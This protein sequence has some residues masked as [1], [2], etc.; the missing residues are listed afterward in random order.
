MR[1][2]N[3]GKAPEFVYKDVPTNKL[4]RM[5]YID[6]RANP[7]IFQ[8]VA[9]TINWDDEETYIGG[10]FSEEFIK[11]FADKINWSYLTK[12]QS[13][14]HDELCKY[15]NRIDWKVASQYQILPEPIISA[16]R[17]EV[18]WDAIST[19]QTLNCAFID[20][21]NEYVNWNRVSKSQKLN[22][23]LLIKY[24]DKI[25]WTMASFYQNSS[26]PIEFI[27]EHPEYIE[28][29]SFSSRL[30]END[31]LI[32]EE[33]VDYINWDNIHFALGIEFVVLN[34]SYMNW[35]N[36]SR[37]E[38]FTDQFIAAYD[39]E[40]NWEIASEYQTLS[41]DVIREHE[42]RVD[43]EKISIHQTLSEPFIHEYK[44]SVSWVHIAFNQSLS[45]EFIDDHIEYLHKYLIILF[46]R[47]MYSDEFINEFRLPVPIEKIG[48][49]VQPTY[50]NENE[51]FVTITNDTRYVDYPCAHIVSGDVVNAVYGQNINNK[52]GHIA[53]GDTVT[54]EP[55]KTINVFL[56]NTKLNMVVGAGS[57]TVPLNA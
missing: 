42:D 19:C 30:T 10:G 43:W 25:N 1:H 26:I 23:D 36:V 31:M 38:T 20:M 17:Y 13:F 33:F 3:D 50:E 8:E 5:A 45:K 4:I 11:E 39:Y 56:I 44:D 9:A 18:D 24:I 34:E 40:I 16:H 22:Y 37:Y 28:W 32:V 54:I 52:W 41:E 51:Y 49:E 27:R 21:M 46:D 47:D 57:Y 48:V 35:D 2:Y 15:A 7:G 14:E 53:T 29:S 6:S 55:G 12:Y